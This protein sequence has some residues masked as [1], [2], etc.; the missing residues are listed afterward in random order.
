MTMTAAARTQMIGSRNP[1]RKPTIENVKQTAPID[2]D[3]DD[4]GDQAGARRCELDAG[5]RPADG[6][7]RLPYGRRLTH[8]STPSRWVGQ[9]RLTTT[10]PAI[11]SCQP[12]LRLSMKIQM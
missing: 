8:A 9:G 5:R 10:V 12:R 3:V 2:E 6:F 1:M 7:R 4:V 11:R